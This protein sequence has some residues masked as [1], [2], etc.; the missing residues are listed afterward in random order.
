MWT[1]V[2]P[3]LVQT[4]RGVGAVPE[5]QNVDTHS[6]GAHSDFRPPT[7]PLGA[8]C[9][10]G[11][12]RTEKV[13]GKLQAVGKLCAHEVHTLLQGAYTVEQAERPGVAASPPR[14]HRVAAFKP[15]R[16]YVAARTPSSRQSGPAP[17][18]SS[19]VAAA[20]L[21]R[22]AAPRRARRWS[23]RAGDGAGQ[24]RRRIGCRRSSRRSRRSSR[25]C[26][27]APRASRSRTYSGSA[28]SQ[29]HARPTPPCAPRRGGAAV[30]ASRPRVRGP[31]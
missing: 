4:W 12:L 19:R 5:A 17:P 1:G 20:A 26:A 9:R 18:R 11:M 25:G 29:R 22:F 14:S 15:R 21:P 16:R 30:T 6:V 2:S 7:H 10:A 23:L 27:R 13:V 24:R 28:P 31:L 3:F 8:G